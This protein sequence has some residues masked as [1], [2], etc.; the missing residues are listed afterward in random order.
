VIPTPDAVIGG[1]RFLSRGKPPPNAAGVRVALRLARTLAGDRG[2]EE[3]AAL[4]F[5]FTILRHDFPGAWRSL[6]LVLARNQALRVGRVLRVDPAE[7]EA[8][9]FGMTEGLVS[10]EDIRAWLGSVRPE[11]L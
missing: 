9:F 1:Y 2:D 11:R 3:P 8:M 5:S 4:L 6:A 10:Y 7:E